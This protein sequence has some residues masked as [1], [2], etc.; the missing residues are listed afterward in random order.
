MNR[1]GLLMPLEQTGVTKSERKFGRRM[2]LCAGL[3]PHVEPGHVYRGHQFGEEYLDNAFTPEPAANMIKRMILDHDPGCRLKRKHISL[4]KRREFL[5]STDE[6]FRPVNMYNSPDGALYV[7]DMYRGI[8]QHARFL[9]DHLRDHALEH[10]LHIPYGKYGR[11][12]RIVRDDQ[13]ID[14]NTPKFSE[15]T[16]TEITDY[17]RHRNGHLRDQAQ[18]VLVQCSPSQVV[19]ILEEMAGSSSEA[20]MDSAACSVDA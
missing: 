3:P 20:G 14:Y 13:E 16:P 18:Q 9:T 4:T 7:V 17:L 15:L 12:Y 5:T 2:E 6:R 10:D 11:I 8:I 19:S 1:C